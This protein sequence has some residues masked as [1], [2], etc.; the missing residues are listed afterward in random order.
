MD[1]QGTLGH[2]SALPVQHIQNV[3]CHLFVRSDPVPP[4]SALV[5]GSAVQAVSQAT[6]LEALRGVPLATPVPLSVQ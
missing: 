4:A 3:P 6:T 5:S 1:I 2:P